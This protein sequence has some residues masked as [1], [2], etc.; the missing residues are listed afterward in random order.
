MLVIVACSSSPQTKPRSDAYAKGFNATYYGGMTPMHCPE[1]LIGT[2]ESV[3]TGPSTMENPPEVTLR[4]H[5]VLRGELRPG[6]TVKAVWSGPPHEVPDTSPQI[7]ESRKKWANVPIEKPGVGSKFLLAGIMWEDGRGRLLRIN[8][9]G[10]LPFTPQNRR[11]VIEQVA[12]SD[13]AFAHELARRKTEADALA[14][15][16]RAWRAGLDENTIAVAAAKADLVALGAMTGSGN[17]ID[18][19]AVTFRIDELL[20]GGQPDLASDGHRYLR[21]VILDKK[22]FGLLDRETTYILL[23]SSDGTD[24]AG[25]PF[26]KP[27]AGTDGL[28]IADPAAR[29]AARRGIDT[30]K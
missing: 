28:V 9:A 24:S 12:A 26:F 22:T 15:D 10:M 5:E 4:V 6:S 19:Y 13:A 7:E 29:I 25:V 23:L 3:S 30:G 17:R 11:D 8:P 18:D 16:Q 20:K 27:V 2:V 1:I 21:R 14:T